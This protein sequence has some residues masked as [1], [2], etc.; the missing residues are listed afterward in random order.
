M[1][2]AVYADLSRRLTEQERSSLFEALDANVLGSG[3]VG[4]QKGPNDEV[5]FALEALNEAAASAQAVHGMKL[6]LQKAAFDVEYALT[7]QR[8]DRA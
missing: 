4:L 2:Y 6:I 5:Y 7:L 8:M 3:C 1:Q